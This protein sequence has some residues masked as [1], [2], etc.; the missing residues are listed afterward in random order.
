MGC[1]VQKNPVQT[2]LNIDRVLA[3]AVQSSEGF[4]APKHLFHILLVSSSFVYQFCLETRAL[5]ANKWL[6]GA[7]GDIC[8]FVHILQKKKK[9]FY[10]IIL[11]KPLPSN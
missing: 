4:Q 2:S 1:Q 7:D 5:T 9:T 3:P 6:K 8:F 10:P 11:Q